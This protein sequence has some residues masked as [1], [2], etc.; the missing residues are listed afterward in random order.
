M[1][2]AIIAVLLFN[3]LRFL[4]IEDGSVGRDVVATWLLAGLAI[5]F[6]EEVLTRGLVVKMMRTPAHANWSSRWSPRRSSPL[7]MRGIS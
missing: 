1:W 6:A 7:C 5:G 3:V 4:T 2:I